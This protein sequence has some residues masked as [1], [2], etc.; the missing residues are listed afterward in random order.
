MTEIC[1]SCILLSLI[2][3]YCSFATRASQL[4]IWH[5]WVIGIERNVCRCTF[6]SYSVITQFAKLAAG[7]Q[8]RRRCPHRK[9]QHFKTFKSLSWKVTHFELW[10]CCVVTLLCCDTV[11]LWHCC[12]VTLLSQ[13]SDIS[14]MSEKKVLKCVFEPRQEAAGARRNLNKKGSPRS[15]SSSDVIRRYLGSRKR[16]PYVQFRSSLRSSFC[17]P[18]AVSA[19]EPLVGF[20]WNSAGSFLQRGVDQAWV[21]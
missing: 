16:I 19:T 20:S 7:E 18:L 17:Y 3:T 12:V 8:L 1:R 11:V 15:H 14:I 9:L 21:C 10:H 6:N 13:M 4:E 5:F 2:H